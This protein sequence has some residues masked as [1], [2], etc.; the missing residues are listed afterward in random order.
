MFFCAPVRR[1]LWNGR[2]GAEMTLRF[3][4]RAACGDA[5]AFVAGLSLV[6][7]FAPF[8]LRALSLLAPAVVFLLWRDVTPK[9]AAWRGWLFGLGLFG[10]GVS[11]V[12]FS[13]HQFGA[14]IAPLAALITLFF[15]TAMALFHATL[16]WAAGRLR[17]DCDAL[18]L[19][20]IFPALWVLA[21]WWRGWFLTGF[22]WLLLGHAQADTW[23][24]GYAPVVGT[25]GTGLTV[26]LSAGL[27]A[28]IVVGRGRKRIAALALIAVLWLGGA[29]LGRIE[30]TEP[31][32]EAVKV[33]LVQGN[34]TQDRKF[35]PDALL[36][37]RDLYLGLTERVAA[38]ALVIWPETAIPDTYDVLAPDLEWVAGRQRAG[39]GDFLTGVF[40]YDETQG[41]YHNSIARP[42]DPPAAYHKRH[43]VIFGEYLPLRWML[44]WLDGF[45]DI[46]M[47]DLAPGKGRPLIEVA[48]MPVGVSVCFEAAFGSE[49]IEALPEAQLLINVS[50]D[51]WF[52]DSIAPHQHL[53]I[54][55]MRAIE[56]GR[57][58]ARATNTGISAVIDER[59][60]VVAR[61]HQFAV[62]VVEAQVEPRSGMTPYAWF[63][64]WPAV[65][66]ALAIL[67]V[68]G[69]RHRR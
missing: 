26:A 56:T 27:L 19:V 20:L 9:R 33:A 8:E 62:D 60:R 2:S 18:D 1:S 38:D 57:W 68:A 15:V 49:M 40:V 53:E 46:P 50:N 11:W 7:A 32:G 6:G 5:L 36:A 17:T 66:V 16:G 23:L 47:S 22:P 35:G 39:G 65:I 24:G 64:D 58:L 55:R 10:G 54:S 21:E 51:A 67:L 31:A 4:K 61:S 12:Y 52:G 13:I 48:G 25:F 34:V 41:V 29:A 63:G 3:E 42:D 43:L 37:A 28:W 14:A 45:L 30:W 69:V 44:L 59:G